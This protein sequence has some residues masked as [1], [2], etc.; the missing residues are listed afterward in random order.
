MNAG[1]LAANGGSGGV[2]GRRRQASAMGPGTTESRPARKRVSKSGSTGRSAGCGDV[3]RLYTERLRMASPA[4][5]R[6]GSGACGGWVVRSRHPVH[7]ICVLMAAEGSSEHLAH[8]ADVRRAGRRVR[9]WVR[10]DSRLHG[11]DGAT[12]MTEQL[13]WGVEGYSEVPE[14]GYSEVPERHSDVEKGGSETRPYE[15]VGRIRGEGPSRRPC[16]RRACGSCRGRAVR[17]GEGVRG[18]GWLA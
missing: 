8:V 15:C 18:R 1:R 4:A 16:R 10:L 13:C 14:E 6:I 7:T 5:G 3:A 12:G 2:N 17:G 11:N 9:G